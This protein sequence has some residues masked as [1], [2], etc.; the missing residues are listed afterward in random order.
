MDPT[1]TGAGSAQKTRAE[2]LQAS[3]KRIAELA[4][5][6]DHADKQGPPDTSEQEDAAP[7]QTDTDTVDNLVDDEY[8]TD[9]EDDTAGDYNGEQYFD[10]GGD[11]AGD[12]YGGGDGGDDVY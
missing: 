5:Q 4:E 8:A 12:D 6:G 10:D 1:L 9:E 3:S 2:R 7:Q 11:D